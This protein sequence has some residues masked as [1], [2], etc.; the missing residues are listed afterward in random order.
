MSTAAAP[1]LCTSA[2]KRRRGAPRSRR[3]K[4]SVDRLCGATLPVRVYLRA[5]MLY[6]LCSQ[7]RVRFYLELRAKKREATRPTGDRHESPEERSIVIIAH[8]DI[9]VGVGG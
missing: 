8:D 6:R 9:S 7:E 1:W 3:P 5:L 4:E 2:S